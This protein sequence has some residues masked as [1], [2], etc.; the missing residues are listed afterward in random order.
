[1]AR[2][3]VK[4]QSPERR[5]HWGTKALLLS[6][7]AVAADW[8]APP[9]FVGHS[10]V[11]GIVCYWVALRL[12]GPNRALLVL[13]ASTVALIIKWDQPYSAAIVACE[14]LCVGWAWRHRR[15]PFLADLLYWAVI[16]TPVSWFLYGKVYVIPHPSFVHAIAVQPVNGLIAVWVSFLVLEQLVA[17]KYAVSLTPAQSFR[18]VLLKRYVAFGTLPVLLVG[19]LAA[20]TFEQQILVE[21]RE[22]LKSTAQR[23]AALISR[24]LAEGTTTLQELAARQSDREW[25]LDSARLTKELVTVHAQSG[26]FV[27]L[28]AADSAGQVVAAAPLAKVVDGL[29]PRILPQVTDREYFSVPMETGRSH[30]SGVFRGRGFGQDILVAVSA[31][32]V[33]RSG[34][35]IGVV[36][37]SIKVS[38]INAILRENL[39][40]DAWR[41]LL[42]DR[43]LHVIT[44]RGFEYSSLDDLEGAALGKLIRRK[45]V[46]PARVTMDFNNR[47]TSFLSITMAVPGVDWSLTVQREW[48]DVVRPVV[49]VYL[50]TLVVALA[51]AVIAS[52]FATWSIRDFLSAWR[53]LI[54]FSHAPSS[55]FDLLAR[56]ARLDLPREFYDLLRNLADMAQRLESAQRKRDQ[57]LAELET[58]V[59]ERT[60]ELQDALL[61]AQAADRAKSVF[62]STVSHE[63]RTP[64]TAIF[65][66]ISILKKSGTCSSDLAARTLATLEKSS[67]VLLSV[68]SDVIEYSKLEA[69]GIEIETRPFRPAAL[70][71]EVGAIIEPSATR[72]PLSLRVVPGHALDL[73]WRG[74]V[75]RI[76]QVLLSLAGNAVKFTTEGEVE[77]S[78]RLEEPGAGKPR[79]L[80]FAVKDSG[81]GI[82]AERMESIF[83]PFVQLETNRVSSQAGTGLG[84]SISRRI[85]ELLGGSIALT[86]TVGVGSCFEFWIP[87]KMADKPAADPAL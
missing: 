73:E 36:E 6:F 22:N 85:V 35:R 59:K 14:G 82:P 32:V 69:G 15:N 38:T 68:I 81:P 10:L 60:Q 3:L 9:I 50:W 24:Q 12:I 16:G 17:S 86:S 63:F 78:S 75:L 42:N 56:S 11:L 30:V 25:F 47:K 76:R 87:E 2:S 20:R 23:V 44:G 52:F 46:N 26:M 74:D 49:T 55:Q 29:P 21:A 70:M 18:R 5:I 39:T 58:R 19:L 27:T 8:H 1:M 71:A 57:L 77:I 31:P 64:L 37:G 34:E 45:G 4:V 79:R 48:G 53:N 67:Q 66:G 43:Q 51:T 13:I 62:L 33:A 61:L 54:E 84:L 83:R 80:Y 7:L 65:M 41:V 72:V 28:L 40:G